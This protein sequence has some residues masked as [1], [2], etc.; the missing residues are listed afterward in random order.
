M[1]KRIGDLSRFD[2]KL[3]QLDLPKVIARYPE[4]SAT[5]GADE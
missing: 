5:R 1:R 4:A 2:D 3:S